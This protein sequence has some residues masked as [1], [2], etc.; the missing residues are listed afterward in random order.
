MRSNKVVQEVECV[1]LAE[2]DLQ[3][4]AGD[5]VEYHHLG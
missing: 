5:P 4:A 3:D 1:E 2:Q